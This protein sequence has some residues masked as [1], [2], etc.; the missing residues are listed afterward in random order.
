MFTPESRK[1]LA[2]KLESM[3]KDARSF[4]IDLLTDHLLSGPLPEEIKIDVRIMKAHR[5]LDAL[6][7]D[8]LNGFATPIPPTEEGKKLN[9]SL[10]ESRKQF[11]EWLELT[12]VGLESF[13]AAT[14][15]PKIDPEFLKVQEEN[16]FNEK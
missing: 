12:R 6:L 2:G 4:V 9:Q 3:P 13:L 8:A 5:E 15:I 16:L 7:T 14:P 1:D 11:L 10:F